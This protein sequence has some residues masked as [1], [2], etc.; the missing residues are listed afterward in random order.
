MSPHRPKTA[1][2]L[3]YDSGL[4]SADSVRVIESHLSRCEVCRRE[5]AVIRAYDSMAAEVRATNVPELDW[6]KMEFALRQAARHESKVAKQTQATHPLAFGFVAAAAFA[7]AVPFAAVKA[8]ERSAESP[9]HHASI[10]ADLRIDGESTF[11]DGTATLFSRDGSARA[12]RSGVVLREGDRILTGP[13]STL[14]ARLE[15]GTG[16]ALEP[17]T[18][19]TIKA[20]RE[21]AI[22]I[23]LASG[24]I[25]NRVHPLEANERYEILAGSFRTAVRGTHFRVE[26]DGSDVDVVVTEG[27]V[28]VM[29]AGSS[30]AM[31]R[32]PSGRWSA[33]GV[34]EAAPPR[35]VVL[36]ASQVPLVETVPVPAPQPEQSRTVTPVPRTSTPSL[37]SD[38]V[39]RVVAASSHLLRACFERAARLSPD[40]ERHAALQVDVDASGRVTSAHAGRGTA[41]VLGECAERVAR[42]F[43]F[44]A[45]QAPTSVRVPLDFDRR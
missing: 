16:F 7:A 34:V 28:E 17:S 6:S 38:D 44:P 20:L 2:L 12:I 43:R 45:P 27:A 30:V 25:S 22:E 15:D 42:G 10:A 24:S 32:A 31:V 37:S 9:S 29:A 26:R 23:A 11:A 14:H 19:V 18:D 35:E 40:I 21:D 4:L 36:D 5:L 13:A 41:R 3:A 8:F 39:E 1:A 33:D